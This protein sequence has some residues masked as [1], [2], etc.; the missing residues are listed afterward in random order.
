MDLNFH[1]WITKRAALHEYFFLSR[2]TFRAAKTTTHSTLAARLTG[3]SIELAI[4]AMLVLAGEEPPRTHM[5]GECLEKIPGL[6]SLMANLWG[7]D[8]DFMVQMVDQDINTSQM[9]Y[10][11]AGSYVD[12]KTELI[13]AAA[14]QNAK[15]WTDVTSELYEEITTSLGMAIWENY[16]EENSEKGEIR[17]RIHVPK[18]QG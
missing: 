3:E 14:A 10:G 2:S 17:K 4:K 11:A 8:F 13:A 7:N 9:R 18:I 6:R 5:I 1:P 16:P 12:K 15:T